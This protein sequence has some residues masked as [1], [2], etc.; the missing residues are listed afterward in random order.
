MIFFS[1]FVKN[2]FDLKNE[3]HGIKHEARI[4]LVLTGCRAKGSRAE[5]HGDNNYYR[6]DNQRRN[7]AFSFVEF[8]IG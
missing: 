6:S 1:I 3:P 7:A 8:L 2:L 4:S 5:A